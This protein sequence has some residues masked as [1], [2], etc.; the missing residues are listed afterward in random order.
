MDN[1]SVRQK[2][3]GD[4]CLQEKHNCLNHDYPFIWFVIA[5]NIGVF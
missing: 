5:L 2:P 3:S 4:E 1:A